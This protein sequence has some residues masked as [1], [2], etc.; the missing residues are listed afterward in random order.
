MGLPPNSILLEQTRRSI[1]PYEWSKKTGERDCLKGVEP[2]ACTSA[3][4]ALSPLKAQNGR[5]GAHHVPLCV[6]PKPN[7]QSGGSEWANTRP[8][9]LTSRVVRELAFQKAEEMRAERLRLEM[10][11]ALGSARTSARRSSVTGAGIAPSAPEAISAAAPL[12][13]P[14][15]RRHSVNLPPIPLDAMP[16]PPR[17][18]SSPSKQSSAPRRTFDFDSESVVRSS[19]SDYGDA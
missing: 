1:M 5:G 13:A 9:P 16:Q 18:A 11:L 14:R 4:R 6:L 19:R 17:P 10:G 12:P 7:E 15:Y 8:V 3:R 2:T